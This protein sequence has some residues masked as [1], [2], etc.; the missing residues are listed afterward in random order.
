VN[1]WERIEA[2]RKRGAAPLAFWTRPGTSDAKAVQETVE[3]NTYLKRGILVLPGSRWLDLG[4]NVG[5]FSKLV[6]ASGASRVDAYEAAPSNLDILRANVAEYRGRAFVHH[7]AIVDDSYEE[8]HVTL[9]VGQKPLQQ[10]RHSILK[11]RRGSVPVKVPAVRFSSLALNANIKL[12]VEGCEIGIL[13]RLDRPLFNQLACEWSFDIDPKIA[14][15]AAVMEKL[16]GWYR[17]VEL[18]KRIDWSQQE[19]RWFP[20]NVFIYASGRI[21][22][23]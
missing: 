13:T 21:A 7:G 2:P 16:R 5:G 12:N 8:D 6:M 15:L 23:P 19:Y 20:P 9:H 22:A 14:T 17:R 10:R 3:R 11:D 4:A 1:D 18:S